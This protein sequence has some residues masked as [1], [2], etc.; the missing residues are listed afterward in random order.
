MS[1]ET[2]DHELEGKVPFTRTEK[3]V[4]AALV[5]SMLVAILIPTGF[6]LQERS[7]D[8]AANNELGERRIEACLS[9]NVDQ[10][11]SRDFAVEDKRQMAVTFFHLTDQEIAAL[12]PEFE[13]FAAFAAD[14]FPYR[15]CTPDCVDAHYDPDIPNCPPSDNEEGTS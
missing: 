5:M 8:Q 10:T 3:I 15:A 7:K 9:Y 4:L 12:A 14:A 6:W 2:S 13:E 11:A 1:S